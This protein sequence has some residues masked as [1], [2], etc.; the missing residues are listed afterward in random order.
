MYYYFKEYPFFKKYEEE[1]DRDALQMLYKV[2]DYEFHPENS[3]IIT[4][5]DYG[6][7]FYIL[8]KGKVT[9][10]IPST[11]ERQMTFKEILYF[12]IEEKKWLIL[13]D[14]LQE[15]LSIVQEFIPEIIKVG[16]DGIL[17]LMYHLTEKMLNEDVILDS[18]TRF[19]NFLP[20]FNELRRYK[21]LKD[22]KLKFKVNMMIKV[23]ELSKGQSFGELALLNNSKR[24]ATVVAIEDCDFGVLSK[25]N[26]EKV[27]GQMLRKKFEKKV[28]FLNKFS[29]LSGM[30]RIKKEKL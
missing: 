19:K 25:E 7:T 26:F 9:I 22:K 3:N 27:V 11:V 30:T 23:A 14:K 13:N 15:L 2:I 17:S 10:R 16:Y 28:E 12:L 20:E 6:S 18:Q 21:N 29:F 8:V 4:Y 1:N 5:G 24:A